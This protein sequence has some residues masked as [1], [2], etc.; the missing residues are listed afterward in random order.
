MA[1]GSMATRSGAYRVL[2][3][4]LAKVS[5]V[6]VHSNGWPADPKAFNDASAVVI[7]ADGGGGH[8]AIQKDRK[9]ILSDLVS[10]VRFAIHQDNELIPFPE[11]VTAGTPVAVSAEA[12]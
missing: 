1:S 2:K 8:P 10:L 7:Y 3:R 5:R 4:M 11:R 9:R 12:T 6:T